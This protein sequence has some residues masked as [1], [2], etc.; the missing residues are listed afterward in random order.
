MCVE[1]HIRIIAAGVSLS[2]L[3][4]L[5]CWSLFRPLAPTR[6]LLSP[7]SHAWPTMEP[8]CV[9]CTIAFPTGAPT[10]QQHGP[11][12]MEQ[13]EVGK[14]CIKG[15][16]AMGVGV[17]KLYYTEC[18]KVAD[19]MKLGNAILAAQQ[20]WKPFYRSACFTGHRKGCSWFTYV[21]TGGIDG[22]GSHCDL[23]SGSSLEENCQTRSTDS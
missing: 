4:L 5:S 21:G 22:P 17:T 18:T 12:T 23:F 1:H 8:H 11:Y 6:H 9:P 16:N 15:I 19:R 2:H 14:A 13:L 3:R 20:V 7:L 10:K